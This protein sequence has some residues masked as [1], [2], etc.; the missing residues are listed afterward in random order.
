MKILLVAQNYHPFIGGVEVHARQVAHRLLSQGHGVEVAAGNFAPSR[1]SA[2]TAMLHTSLLAPAFADYNDE[3]VPV[4][5][6]TPT[7]ADR[8]R[9]MPIALR[10]L[11]KLQRYA[12][13]RLNRFGYRWYRS[14]Y[15][16][17]LRELAQ[18][19]DVVHSLAGGYLGWAAQEAAAACHRPFV[20]TPFVHPKQWGDGPEDIAYYQRADAVI[21]LVPTDR[22][23][24][25][26]LGV[27]EQKLHVIGVSPNLP[28]DADAAGFR[29][30]HGLTNLPF[31]LYVGRMMPQKGASA[32]LAAAPAVW[33][34]KPDTHFVFIG[35]ANDAEA[36]Q[37]A[38]AD[39]R[40][41]YLGKV[42]FQEK[43]DALAACTLFCMPSLSEILPTVYLEAW[44][45]GKPV[46]G[47]K[48]HGL[49]ELVE[50]SGAGLSAGQEGGDVA[51]KIMQILCDPDMQARLG[52]QGKRL[53]QE[54]YS[55]PQVTEALLSL[56]RHV[57]RAKEARPA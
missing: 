24:L 6:L 41:H 22:D 20:S 11:P 27:P 43:A 56:Y 39:A 48:A 19:A 34:H 32:V 25:A 29:A 9:M 54:R 2:R 49:P 16:P 18:K 30:R 38:N 13:S 46:I 14:V 28:T 17:R 12:H 50:G 44:S 5:A 57:Q 1:L 23:Y 8:V 47:G 15:L 53:V 36:A 37:F 42:S 26:S 4:H 31:V 40:I 3:G 33:K 52:Q 45:Y 7:R 35:P 51:Q 21:G 55:V 10:A